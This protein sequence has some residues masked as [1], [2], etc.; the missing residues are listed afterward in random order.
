MFVIFLIFIVS[1]VSIPLYL[2]YKKNP[3]DNM[4]I[5]NLKIA[6]D[7]SIVSQV[8]TPLAP[9]AE[10]YGLNKLFI[11]PILVFILFFILIIIF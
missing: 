1:I 6:N 8:I 2:D 9:H 11:L 7:N 10:K 4:I 3:V 5:N